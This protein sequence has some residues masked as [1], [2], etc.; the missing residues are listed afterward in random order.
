MITDTG[1][2]ALV[3]GLDRFQPP[4]SCP[5]GTPLHRGVLIASV[6]R[7]EGAQASLPAYLDR[8]PG[9]GSVVTSPH[10]PDVLVVGTT[11]ATVERQHCR[12]GGVGLAYHAVDAE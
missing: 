11:Q 10:Y 12:V 9:S 4:R 8:T 5:S 6:C 7:T 2:N 1:I 3:T